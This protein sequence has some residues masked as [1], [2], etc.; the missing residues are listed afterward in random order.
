MG[1]NGSEGYY[2]EKLSGA[3]LRRCYEL[4]P[5]RVR[6]YLDA[7]VA[8]VASRLQSG[9]QVLELGCGYGRILER[10]APKVGFLVG[11]DTSAQSLALA[12]DIL[13]GH[14]NCRLARMDAGLPAFHDG[15]FD[16]VLCLQNGL[17]AFKI[18]R[19]RLVSECVRVTRRGGRVL[20]STYAER[21]WEHRLEWF[22]LQSVEGLVGEIDWT[23]TRNG[24][25]VCKDGFRATTIGVAD[26]ESLTTGWSVQRRIEEVD[27]SSLF[28]ELTV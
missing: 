20:L 19:R 18:D 25:I 14:G 1:A 7:E 10:L 27:G 3:R 5:P 23:A 21:F 4:A 28:C 26:F 6:Q 12:R 11:I 9:D 24:E 15:V 2:V 16:A 8:H 22:R 13:A 17:S